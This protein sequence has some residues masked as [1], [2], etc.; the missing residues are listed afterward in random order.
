MYIAILF[1]ILV[2]LVVAFALFKGHTATVTEDPD[3]AERIR[4]SAAFI[5]M[6]NK[7]PA[8]AEGAAT[9]ES[10]T[11][12]APK[13]PASIYASAC[14]ICH[15]TGVAGAPRKGDKEAWSS[16]VTTGMDA[17]YRSAMNGKGA[18]PPRGNTTGISD[19]ELKA[20]VDYLVNAD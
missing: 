16:R 17:L 2:V 1:S 15:D 9:E 8:V 13:D 14:Y 10:A 19:D 7:A 20:V 5:K 12:T 18:M 6:D 3:A 11:E 4:P